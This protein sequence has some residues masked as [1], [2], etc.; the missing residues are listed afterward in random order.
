MATRSDSLAR[1]CSR[2]GPRTSKWKLELRRSPSAAA[3]VG[4]A[5]VEKRE[6]GTRKEKPNEHTWLRV[7]GGGGAASQ[8]QLTHSQLLDKGRIKLKK[9]A[10]R[11]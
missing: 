10:A 5:L 3:A 6:T 11:S 8:R 1:L 9:E 7:G 4:F 2:S